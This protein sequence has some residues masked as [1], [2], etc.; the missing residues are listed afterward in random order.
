MDLDSERNEALR[1]IGRNLVL[2]QQ[3][4]HALK[5]LI[6]NG[7]VSGFVSDLGAIQKK[8]A[9]KIHKQ[10]LGQLIGRYLENTHSVPDDCK[11]P[12]ANQRDM[13][14]AF[15]FRLETD[16][17]DY[18]LRE[19][20]LKSLTA[21]R[22]DLIHHLLPKFDLGSISGCQALNEFLNDQRERLIPELESAQNLATQ[23]RDGRRR[24][25][26]FLTSPEACA[27]FMLLMSNDKPLLNMFADL[28]NENAQ[29]DGWSSFNKAVS[30]VQKHAKEELSELAEKYGAKTL[31][32]AML[33]SNIFE[34]S[35]VP[36]KSVGISVMYRVKPIIF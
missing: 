23:L 15:S 16:T 10:T 35:E 29:Q 6:A 2:F 17:T 31:K 19:E 25:A 28:A 4:E 36:T 3:L 22:N 9:E 24:M 20:T 30:H 12:E 11:P 34:F 5:Y 32:K 27:Q 13:Y 8:R 18:K 26:A 14:V 33:K 7:N 1:R 21:D